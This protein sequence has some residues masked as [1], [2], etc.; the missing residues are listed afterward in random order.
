[1]FKTFLECANVQTAVQNTLG[2]LHKLLLHNEIPFF[3][4]I[5][6]LQP[7]CFAISLK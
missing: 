2:T 4:I 6:S 5:S 7:L 1:M 3:F